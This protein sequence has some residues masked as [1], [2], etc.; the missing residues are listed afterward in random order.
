[1]IYFHEGFSFL[2]TISRFPLQSFLPPADCKKGF[3]LQSGVEIGA[4]VVTF[5]LGI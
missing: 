4:A 3:P 2:A 1:M 5:C